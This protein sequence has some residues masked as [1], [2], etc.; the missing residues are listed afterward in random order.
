MSSKWSSGKLIAAALLLW[1]SLAAPALSHIPAPP[2][3]G[4]LG[5]KEVRIAAPDFALVDQEGKPF[6]LRSLRGKVVLVTFTYT[7]CPDACPLLTAKMA[8]MQRTLKSWALSLRLSR[9][10]R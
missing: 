7:T 5:R 3:K 1:A 4:E 9:P 6:H 8:G 2:K 10:W